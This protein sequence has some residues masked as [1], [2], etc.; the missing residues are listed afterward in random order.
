MSSGKKG[1]QV[2]ESISEMYT[3]YNLKKI[4]PKQ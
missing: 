1:E 4:L 3:K 2:E